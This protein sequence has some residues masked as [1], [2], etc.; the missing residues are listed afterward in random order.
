MPLEIR[1]LHIKVNLNAPAAGGAG[2][3]S[4][5]AQGQGGGD[6]K[7]RLLADCV[8]EVMRLLKDRKER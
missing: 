6:D 1:E 7:E 5:A 3:T 8:D 2:A 4:A